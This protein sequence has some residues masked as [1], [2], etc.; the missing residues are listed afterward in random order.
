MKKL[1]D[2]AVLAWLALRTQ[3]YFFIEEI[4]VFFRFYRRSSFRIRDRAFKKHYRFTNPFRINKAFLLKR[5]DREVDTYGETPLTTWY[6]IARESGIAQGDHVFDLGCGRG[7]GVFFL[8][9]LIG[10]RVTGI[11]WNP[12]FIKRA[13]QIASADLGDTL[14]FHCGDLV[15]CDL[16]SA[17]VIYVFGTC[18]PDEVVEKLTHRLSSL[19]TS[20][21]VI[22][23]S[24]PLSEYSDQFVTVKEW[25]GSFPWG[26]TSIFLTKKKEDRI[27]SHLKTGE[28]HE[29]SSYRKKMPA[30]SSWNCSA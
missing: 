30:M 23:V 28:A 17:T 29:R 3:V 15:D 16:S 26:K 14:F 21:T 6:E 25:I 11:D 22:T 20:T 8:H 10:C 13:Q 7:R 9:D 24:F 1:I 18:L 4:R 2:C 5:G 12:E 27:Q 19:P